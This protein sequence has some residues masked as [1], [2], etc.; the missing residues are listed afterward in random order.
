DF[1]L[2]KA[3]SAASDI[4]QTGFL[5]GTPDYMAP[6]LIDKPESV[7]SDIYSL[8]ILLYHMLTGQPPFSGTTPLAVLWKHVREEAIPPSQL[9]PAIS[10]SVEKVIL[11]AIHKNPKMRFPSAEAMDQA[12]KNALQSSQQKR[13]PL[14]LPIREFERAYMTLKKVDRKT[15]PT[16]ALQAVPK[17]G[18]QNHPLTLQRA[19]LSLAIMAMFVLPLSLGFLMGRDKT[20]VS[21]AFSA[22]QF[23]TVLHKIAPP[24]S[25]PQSAPH[26]ST[27]SPIPQVSTPPTPNVFP[28]KGKTPPTHKT[29]PGPHHKHKNP[30]RKNGDNNTNGHDSTTTEA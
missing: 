28:V 18:R 22:A 4:T 12:Y 29:P 21:P 20:E 1:G 6:E 26:V 9:N 27:S 24:V 16:A 13:V 23:T 11:R 19:I 7:S 14:E 3:V 25:T 30:H 8:G 5:I 10:P 17:V 15:L 2:A